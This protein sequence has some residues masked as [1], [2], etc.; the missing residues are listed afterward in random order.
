MQKTILTII[1]GISIFIQAS[2]QNVEKYHDNIVQAFSL[3]NAKDYHNAVLAFE[4]AFNVL[5]GK[6]DPNHRYIAACSYSLAGNIEKAFYHL[7]RL[8]NKN[9]NYSKYELMINNSDLSSLH[10]DKRWKVIIAAVKENKEDKEKLIPVIAILENIYSE[11]QKIR[12]QI[13]EKAKEL[14]RNSDEFKEIEKS[15]FKQDSINFEKIIKILDTHGWLG[16]NLVGVEANLALFLVIQHADLKSQLKYLPIMREANK[17]GN[18]A[19]SQLALVEDRVALRQG[20]KQIYGSQVHW[21]E[22]AQEYFVSPIIDP[23]NVDHR[24]TSMG[25]VPISEYVKSWNLTWDIK[26]H[27][28]RKLIPEIKM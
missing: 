26:K 28:L 23:E 21:D 20:N 12:K 4:K 10:K 7:T 25:L 8:T 17:V 15:I 22:K 3:Y 13:F 16:H 27:K 5:D 1:L 9:S 6:A 11:D 19:S 18:L 14:G 2:S 24:R